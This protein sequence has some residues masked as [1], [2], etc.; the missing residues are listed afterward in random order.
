M[1]EEIIGIAAG[2]AG[3]MTGKQR[4]RLLA[5][6]GEVRPERGQVKCRLRIRSVVSV[7]TSV[8]CATLLLLEPVLTRS[9]LL[10][11]A[12]DFVRPSASSTW[13][14]A[15]KQMGPPWVKFWTA[16][17]LPPPPSPAPNAAA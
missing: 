8:T 3:E 17:W 16:S 5:L 4:A 7:N 9:P 6:V 10:I 1:N 11:S 2:V 13:V 12:I 14:S 15:A